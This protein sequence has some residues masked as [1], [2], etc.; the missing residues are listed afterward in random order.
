MWPGGI[1][2]DCT[3]G[4]IFQFD[5]TIKWLSYKQAPSWHDLKC[6]E[7]DNKPNTFFF[8][9]LFHYKGDGSWCWARINLFYWETS[10]KSPSSLP[11]LPQSKSPSN[12]SHYF[13]PQL[14]PSKNPFTTSPSSHSQLHDK[15]SLISTAT[16]TTK[17]T[18][19]SYATSI[20]SWRPLCYYMYMYFYCF[21][22]S[23]VGTYNMHVHQ[24]RKSMHINFSLTNMS[25]FVH[26]CTDSKVKK[27]LMTNFCHAFSMVK[28]VNGHGNIL[29]TSLSGTLQ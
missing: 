13:H 12:T 5:S 6:V 14:R 29:S 2:Y 1:S 16:P 3:C 11:Q 18:L 4:V 26:T 20:T 23:S 22:C 15:N 9:L 28:K 17:K 10:S 25:R 21:S 24:T 27:I 7:M 8:N 19:L